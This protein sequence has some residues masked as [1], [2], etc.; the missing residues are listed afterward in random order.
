[1]ES[2]YKKIDRSMMDWGITLPKDFISN[3][4]GNIKLKKGT[5][6]DIELLWDKQ[7]FSVKLQH[8]NRK[9]AT[10]VYQIRWDNNKDFLKK[11]RKT[12]IQSYVILKSQK[13]LFDISNK[14][15]KHF[16][17]NLSGGQQEVII[18]KPI[19]NKK[20]EL[21]VFIKIENGWNQLFERLADENVFGWIFNKDKK[22]LIQRSTNWIDVENFQRHVNEVNVIY[23]LANTRRKLLYIG[24][25]EI[26][27]N[28]VRPGRDHQSMPGDWDLFKYDII[29]PE[30]SNILERLED[31]TIRS[32]AA[33]LENTKNYPSL[34]LSSYK[35]VNSSW[36]KL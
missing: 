21:E 22:Y 9:T 25:A 10:S 18:F 12:F 17:T 6:R 15:N 5:S 32:F 29:R 24:K 13:E 31:H 7:V 8:V 11:L 14:E 36:K 2:Y 35:L 27:G 30:Y 28:R 23:Y 16:R 34:R 20:I 4:E 19:T 3:F 33:V 26:L 1:M